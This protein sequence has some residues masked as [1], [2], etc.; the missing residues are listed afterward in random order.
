MLNAQDA[1][2]HINDHNDQYGKILDLGCF[3]GVFLNEA[4]QA[5]WE[6]Y[7][8]EPLIMP[9]IYARGNYNLNVI[10]DT[11]R[12]DSYSPEFFDVVTT[13]Q[14]FEHLIFPDE[15]LRKIQ[16]ILKPGGLL[17]IEVPNI[18]TAWVK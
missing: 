9:A 16:R 3:C 4:S 1:L 13:F 12:N 2:R 18:D 5:G 7:G 14:V 8:I 10:T 11:L 6:C 15:E 17:M